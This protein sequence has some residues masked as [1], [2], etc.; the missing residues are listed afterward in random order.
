[1]RLI[2]TGT[3][4][5]RSPVLCAL[6]STPMPP[7]LSGPG[8]EAAHII[9]ERRTA[10]RKEWVENKTLEVELARPTRAA[11]RIRAANASGKSGF[12]NVVT[13]ELGGEVMRGR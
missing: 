8:Q 6:K 7:G 9:V 5:P 13:V 12:S 4:C 2:S 1:M 11:Y 3:C 10:P